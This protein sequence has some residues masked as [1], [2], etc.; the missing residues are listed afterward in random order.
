V[1]FTFLTAYAYY[2]GKFTNCG[3]FGDC[4]PITPF[5]SFLKDLIL[6]ICIVFLLVFHTYL[7]RMTSRQRP[8]QLTA[9]SV[10]LTLLLQW[11]VLNYLPLADCL[12]FKKGNNIAAQMKPAPGSVPDSFE[13]LFQYTKNGKAYEFTPEQLPA[14]F[15][16]YTYVDRKD[17]LIRKGNADPAIKGFALTGLSGA[18]STDVFLATPRALVLFVQQ[19]RPESWVAT[20]RQLCQEAL[21]KKLPVYLI[22]SE[23]QRAAQLFGSDP[24]LQLFTC[25]FTVM[26]TAARTDPTL[27]II[28]NGTIRDK[29]G[30]RQL[31]KAAPY[32]TSLR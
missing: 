31:K 20:F 17:K 3:C 21:R 28:E 12:P 24:E 30:K 6:L 15:E 32:I 18:D 25:D 1:F 11:Y 29:F 4:L 19:P 26:R 14:D 13:I 23:V 8:F 9:I 5:T 10:V 22:T 2:S 7:F 27:Y 16:T